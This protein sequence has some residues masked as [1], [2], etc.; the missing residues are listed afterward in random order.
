MYCSDYCRTEAKKEQ[1][2]N[3]RLRYYYKN[4]QKEQYTTPG[5]RT[6]GP[7]PA[8]TFEKEQKIIQNEKKRMGLS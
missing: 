8:D 6:I 3:S 4:R 1:D 5:T 7:H 2:R